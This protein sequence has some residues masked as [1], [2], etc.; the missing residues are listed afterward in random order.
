MESATQLIT[1]H[2]SWKDDWKRTKIE[3]L[4]CFLKEQSFAREK[5]G[6]KMNVPG[7][8]LEK[9]LKQLPALRKP[10]VSTLSE[11]AGYAVET[12]VDQSIARTLFRH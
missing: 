7:D 8:S 1:N 2:Q 4:P 10:T 11:G 3:I 6:L 9:V 12:M 5:V